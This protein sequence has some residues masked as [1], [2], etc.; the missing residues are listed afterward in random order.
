MAEATDSVSARLESIEEVSLTSLGGED[1]ILADSAAVV[2]STAL[3]RL[4]DVLEKNWESLT[5]RDELIEV[6]RQGLRKPVGLVTF[7]RLADAWLSA[8]ALRE[9][10]SRTLVQDLAAVAGGAS[11]PLMRA[12]AMEKLLRIAED[13]PAARYQ[14]IASAM[15]IDPKATPAQA[16]ARIVRVLGAAY[17][18]SG[19]RDL[20]GMLD[21]FAANDLVADAVEFERALIR[22]DMGLDAKTESEAVEN[23]TAA[24][25]GLG[26]AHRLDPEHL[27]AAIYRDVLDCVL[28]FR[29]GC[30]SAE[31]ADIAHRLKDNV[32]SQAMLQLNDQPRA[33][34]ARRLTSQAQWAVVADLLQRLAGKLER[35]TWIDAG[36]ALDEVFTLYRGRMPLGDAARERPGLAALARR[37]IETSFIRR[38][39]QLG[40]LEEYVQTMHSEDW[41]ETAT[42]LLSRIR[43]RAGSAPPGKP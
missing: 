32:N 33:W 19:D 14:L 31:I 27:E 41:G 40:L 10:T 24:R 1:A 7:D 29:E 6:L 23:L 34:I 11:D 39:Q 25:E 30:P 9:A 5:R 8:P 36:K 17:E 2:V 38:Q 16:I 21:A 22:I 15:S 43:E 3:P 4:V 42:L 35:P 28:L 20:F 13:D 12:A 18:L 37:R 26:R